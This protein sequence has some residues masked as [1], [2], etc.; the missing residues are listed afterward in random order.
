[1]ANAFS[2][3]LEK[4]EAK[5][6]HHIGSSQSMD[7]QSND[8]V[9]MGFYPVFYL[10]Y[11]QLPRMLEVHFERRVVGH[12]IAVLFG[13]PKVGHNT[14]KF[15]VLLTKRSASLRF[16]SSALDGENIGLWPSTLFS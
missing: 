10:S 7:Y 3:A 9:S 16:R 14:S 6:D 15:P 8:G 13:N 1:V 12:D 5:G 11:P 2:L 4:R